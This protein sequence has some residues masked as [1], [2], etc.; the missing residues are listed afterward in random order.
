MDN[1]IDNISLTQLPNGA[2]FNY[3]QA[4][5]ERVET[6]S[7]AKAKVPNELAALKS[8]FATEDECLNVSRKNP[9][10]TRSARPT[11]ARRLLHG[12]QERREG[13]PATPRGRHASRR[14]DALA[15]YR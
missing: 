6:D 11:P 9:S 12:L 1:T 15:A 2:H 13:I 5:I 4:S 10:P 3:M 14:Q 7:V 8:A